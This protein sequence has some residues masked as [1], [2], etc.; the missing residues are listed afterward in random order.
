MLELAAS[1]TISTVAGGLV[2]IESVL[3][4]EGVVTRIASG[5]SSVPHSIR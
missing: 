5:L 2:C 4:P 1:F 3:V